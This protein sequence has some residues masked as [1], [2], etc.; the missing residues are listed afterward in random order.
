M[1]FDE[2][3]PC[4]IQ[5]NDGDA[6]AQHTRRLLENLRHIPVA[7]Q[8]GTADELVPSSGVVAPGRAAD[9]ARLPPPLYLFHTQEHFGPPVW[10]QWGEGG[11]YMHQFTPPGDARRAITHVRDMPFERAIERVK[12][13][14]DARLRLR[15][16]PLAARARARDAENGRATFDGTTIAVPAT[17]PLRAR[18]RRPGRRPTRPARTR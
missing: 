16:Q 3:S 12:A 13:A 2:Y 6:R 8:H 11:R 4:Y 15:P 18:G 10:D 17:D 7:I 14:A 1:Q 9:R 5:A